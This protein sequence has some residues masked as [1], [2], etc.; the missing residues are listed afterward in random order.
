MPVLLFR[1]LIEIINRK[2]SQTQAVKAGACDALS[3]PELV[4]REER[5]L[6]RSDFPQAIFISIITK[7]AQYQD[8]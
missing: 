1:V 6:L 4:A 3:E 7:E 2:K 5:L 8:H